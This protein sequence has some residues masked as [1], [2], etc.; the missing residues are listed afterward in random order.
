M[1]KYRKKYKYGGSISSN[2]NNNLFGNTLNGT[3]SGAGTGA[4]IGGMYGPKGMAIGAIGG[5]L[6]GGVSS[7][8]AGNNQNKQ[9]SKSHKQ[10][11]EYNN[12]LMSKF[13][14]NRDNAMLDSH[15]QNGYMFNSYFK[16][17]G[18]LPNKLVNNSSTSF[19]AKGNT[20]E[21]GGINLGDIEV[22]DG[23]VINEDNVYSDRIGKGN[24]SFANS[25]KTLTNKKGVLEKQFKN[26]TSSRRRN[27]IKREIDYIDNQLNSLY[28][29]QEAL[30][31]PQFG[32][33]YNNTLAYGGKINPSQMYTAI[34]TGA[35]FI[36]NIYNSNL[37]NNRPNIPKPYLTPNVKLNSNFNIQPQLR[38]ADN[39]YNDFNKSISNTNSGSIS[40]ANKIKA[41]NNTLSYKNNLLSEKVNREN[42]INNQQAQINANI[43]AN[44]VNSL[45]RYNLMNLERDNAVQQA[46]SSNV[47]D[48]SRDIQYSTSEQNLREL[49]KEKLKL[50]SI[51]YRNSG[52]MA[53]I[54]TSPTMQSAIS[55]DIEMYRSVEQSLQNRPDDLKR[56]YEV[57]GR[58]GDSETF[59][60]IFNRNL[61]ILKATTNTSIN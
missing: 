41:F 45:N 29:Q 55:S 59:N 25:A 44:N 11:R 49:E 24:Q 1:K 36:D 35:R 58:K 43:D 16:Y 15:P 14:Y 13:N 32:S 33:Q 61:N 23:E 2:Y 9:L 54:M 42:Q 40:R 22:E 10:L 21:Q 26:A 20:H 57:F 51:L 27:S 18:K 7:Y 53:N 60:S 46:K 17:G 3:L 34:G 52:V 38:Q 8:I 56:F 31:N 50:N 4:S 48:L 47:A 6:A 39:Q 37:N 28:E 30:K 19:V 12:Q 5:A